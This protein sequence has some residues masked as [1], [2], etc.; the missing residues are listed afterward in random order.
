MNIEWRQEERF[1]ASYHGH[2]LI[3]QPMIEGSGYNCQLSHMNDD[4]TNMITFPIGASYNTIEEAK[5]AGV[6]YLEEHLK[7]IDARAVKQWKD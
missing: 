5:I 6:K 1:Y 4:G 3:V 7:E 2:F